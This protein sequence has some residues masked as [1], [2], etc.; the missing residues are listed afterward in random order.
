MRIPAMTSQRGYSLAEMLVVTGIAGILALGGLG[1]ADLE[2]PDLTAAQVELKGSLDQAFDLSYNSGQNVVVSMSQQKDIGHVPVHLSRRVHWGKPAQV[3]MPPGVDAPKA[4]AQ[5]ESQK[6]IV[7]TPR[8]TALAT[9][10][11]LHDGHD[12]LCVRVNT[13]GRILMLRWCR[14][15]KTWRKV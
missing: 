14:E 12:V 13:Q 8:H 4:A 5:G 11:F 9:V 6:R 3:P 1:L 7:V 15:R 10:W 2:G